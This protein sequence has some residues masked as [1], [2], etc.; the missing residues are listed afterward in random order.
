MSGLGKGVSGMV[1]SSWN[2]VRAGTFPDNIPWPPRMAT[3]TGCLNNNIMA[4]PLLKV[5]SQSSKTQQGA[6]LL[7]WKVRC[8][9]IL[10]LSHPPNI[11]TY[12]LLKQQKK[13]PGGCH[14]WCTAT[15]Y[16]L[17]QGGMCPLL[18]QLQF[19]FCRNKGWLNP[20]GVVLIQCSAIPKDL[21]IPQLNPHKS[22][23]IL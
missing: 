14:E 17:W 2:E 5:K 1:G 20:Q 22:S 11:P 16:S 18:N 8:K 23:C 10:E 13:G 15:V 3:K 21:N 19:P 12:T 9:R 6:T 7:I 4:L